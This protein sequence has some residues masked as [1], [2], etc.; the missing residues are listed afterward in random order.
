[1][2]DIQLSGN[3]PELNGKYLG[4]ITTDFVKVAATLREAAEQLTLRKIS[5]Y[6]VFAMAKGE[7]KV[8]SLLLGKDELNLDWNYYFTFAEDLKNR[9]LIEDDKLQYFVENY[10]NPSEFCCLLVIDGKF[11]CFLYV[12]YPED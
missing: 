1:M 6:P 8:G 3:D 7:L 9:G 4:T 10:K 12:P 11:T 5:E 2:E